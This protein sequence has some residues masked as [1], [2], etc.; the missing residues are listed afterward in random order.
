MTTCASIVD[1]FGGFDSSHML[2]PDGQAESD[3]QD[4][5]GCSYHGKFVQSHLLKFNGENPTCAQVN[6]D[7]NRHRVCA[8]KDRLVKVREVTCRSTRDKVLSESQCNS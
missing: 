3:L 2:S 4:A 7:A 5:S 6:S 1:A 8:C